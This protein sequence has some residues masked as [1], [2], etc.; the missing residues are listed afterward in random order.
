MTKLSRPTFHRCSMK[1]Q[2]KWLGRCH[3]CIQFQST[4]LSKLRVAAGTA[5]LILPAK[6]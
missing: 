1:A 4:H 6:R 2:C 5:P 3:A